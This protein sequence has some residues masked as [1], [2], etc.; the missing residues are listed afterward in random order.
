MQLRQTKKWSVCCLETNC[1][2]LS[3]KCAA[4][5][6]NHRNIRI[7]MSQNANGIASNDTT[8]NSVVCCRRVLWLSCEQVIKGLA[9]L[10]WRWD[11]AKLLQHIKHIKVRPDFHDLAACDAQDI[12]AP[13]RHVQAR[14]RDAH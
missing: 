12:D 8:K 14:G 11:N 9:G 1:V 10:S 3:Q 6:L 7:V 4:L 13:D 5:H 2:R